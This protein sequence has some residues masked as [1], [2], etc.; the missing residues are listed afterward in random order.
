MVDCAVLL[1]NYCVA[2]LSGLKLFRI[3]SSCVFSRPFAVASV[4][5]EQGALEENIV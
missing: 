1:L 3:W 4:M 5:Q 2:I